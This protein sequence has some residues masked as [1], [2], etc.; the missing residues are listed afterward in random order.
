LSESES[1]EDESEDED[2]ER[3]EYDVDVCP[4]GCS[5]ALYTRMCDERENRVDIEEV[6]TS[7]RSSRDA[8]IKD[9]EQAKKRAKIVVDLVEEAEEK[10]EAFQVCI[11][12]SEFV[13]VIYSLTVTE[14]V[15]LSIVSYRIVN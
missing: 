6:I 1:S 14:N 13:A 9:L 7:E 5:Q 2:H 15:K 3:E 10:L 12:S 4:P 11:Q 8:L